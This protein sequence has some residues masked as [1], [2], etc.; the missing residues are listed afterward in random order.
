MIIS[1][2]LPIF[3]LI[4]IGVLLQRQ[5]PRQPNS[6]QL[7]CQVGL[8]SC[9]TWTSVLNK[10]ALYLALPALIFSSLVEAER[11]SLPSLELILFTAVLL[12]ATLGIVY[13]VAST[14][15]TSVKIRN[16]YLFGTFFGNIAY[17]GPPF[18]VALYGTDIL[19]SL[20]IIIAIHIAI[21]FS[22]GLFILETS[23]PVHSGLTTVL[24]TLIKNP[25]LL[26]V[27]VGLIIL[28][29]GI[30]LPASV[31]Q[32]IHMLGASASP[33]VLI[34]LGTFIATEWDPRAH[35]GHVVAISLLKLMA[36]PLLFLFVGISMVAP[37]VIRDISILEAAMPVAI[38][39]FALA[40]HYPID[41]KII[42]NAIILSTLLSIITL[43]VFSH[44][45]TSF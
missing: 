4:G 44:V 17:I 32:A 24:K 19:G 39:S 31:I 36:M 34:A 35:I 28:L 25:I 5:L 30:Q 40:E 1:A 3:I 18:L 6:S 16:T 43:T 21:A 42:A 7:L 14:L 8:G 41:K 27:L 11:Q 13:A 15:H 38:T 23:K 12:L 33:V 22:I 20:S 37:S 29:T 10:F 2:I 9:E 26:S 45:L